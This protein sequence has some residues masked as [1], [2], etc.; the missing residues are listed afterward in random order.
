MIERKVI[1]VKWRD[2]VA[3]CAM[4][5]SG[6]RIIEMD[7]EDDDDIEDESA[8]DSFLDDDAV[9]YDDRPESYGLGPAIVGP[10]GIIP[11]HEHN[12]PSRLHNFWMAH[13]NF[14]LRADGCVAKIVGTP[15]VETFTPFT[16]YRFR[17]SVGRLFE[18]D[19][20]KQG[21]TNALCPLPITSPAHSGA[22]VAPNPRPEGGFAALEKM[23]RR[24]VGGSKFW[25]IFNQNGK[26][27]VKT[28]NT[29]EEVVA[30]G[31]GQEVVRSW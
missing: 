17:I 28:G 3:P 14:D 13:T 7:T 31:V 18:Q 1:W 12:I 8:R 26:Y 9:K 4:D 29:P 22:V 24:Q 10:N 27:E 6:R 21:V 25:A 20:V 23:M 15:G 5:K 16:R 30:K 11:L 2:P 19:E